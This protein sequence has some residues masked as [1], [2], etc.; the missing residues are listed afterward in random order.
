VDLAQL[1]IATALFIAT[2]VYA[3][4]TWGMSKEMRETRRLSIRP[5]LALAVDP[6]STFQGLL[7]V[8][9]LGPGA[10]CDVELRL[11][12]E[13]HSAT[14]E[15][16]APFLLSG[17][18]AQFKALGRDGEKE[19]KLETLAREGVVVRLD[20]SMR[21]VD[22]RNH[23]VADEVNIA[24]WWDMALHSD[25]RYLESV[26]ERIVRE[27]TKISKGLSGGGGNGSE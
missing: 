20:G 4:F 24:E 17:E 13:P 1:A 7:S 3:Y 22:G 21:D 6:L 23:E 16:A 15:W 2:V 14:R 25:Q 26:G 19:Y 5:R 27:L 8:Q 9:N 10:A 12:F 18:K 11:T